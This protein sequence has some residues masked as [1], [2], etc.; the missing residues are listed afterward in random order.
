[1]SPAML[2]IAK[3]SW[4]VPTNVLV[5]LE[6]D[7]VVGVVGDRAARRDRREPGAAPRAE[8]AVDPIAVQVGARA[9][10]LGRDALGHER[11][12]GLPVGV[13]QRAIRMGAAHEREQRALVPVVGGDGRDELLREDVEGPRRDRERVERALAHRADEGRALDE[14]V[15][16]QREH[17][18]LRRR[19]ER[20]ARAADALEQRRDRARRADLHD[21]LDGADVDPELEGR[22]RDDAADLGA[23]EPRLGRQPQ[24]ARQAAVVCG[25]PLLAEPRRELVREALDEAAC[26]DED[27]RRAVREDER[28]DP[29]VDL[30][31]LGVRRDGAEGLARDLD[32]ELDVPPRAGVDDDGPGA[33]TD[34]EPRDELDRALRRREADAHRRAR[35]ER[36]EALE[37]QRE[38]CAPLVADDRVDLVDDHGVDACEPFA[39][40]RRGQQDVE[41]LGRRDEDVRRA[42]R[43]LRAL[44]RGGVAGADADA[45][46]RELEPLGRSSATSSARGPSRFFATSFDSAF[47]GDT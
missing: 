20:V 16:R 3:S 37:A 46:R 23:L 22:G 32:R 33:R 47:S 18:P 6:H 13:A 44:A 45:D 38:V 17:S 31:E 36:V 1:M 9:S 4:I 11:E 2:S 28:R 30:V 43:H 24:R 15:P 7:A 8:P 14:L 42:L 40:P 34:E 12:H 41:R 29:I 10:L 5:G 25:D 27:D 39:R 26:V 35:D 19:A 21:E